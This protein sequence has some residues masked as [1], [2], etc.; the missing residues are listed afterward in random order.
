MSLYLTDRISSTGKRVYTD[1]GFLIIKGARIARSGIQ[2][3][4]AAE[5]P[6]YFGDKEPTDLVS[7]YRPDTEV[8]D[9]ES[10]Q[11]FENKAFAN[12]HP[13]ELIEVR[14]YKDLAIGHVNNIRRDGIFLLADI[15]VI[16]E[17]TIKDIEAGK[18]ELSNGY[19][20]TLVIVKGVTADNE[21]YDAVQ[22]K[23]RG[24]HV[25]L[26]DKARCGPVCSLSDSQPREGVNMKIFIDGV[27][28]EVADESLSAAIQKV[29]TQNAELSS[30]LSNVQATHDTAVSSLKDSYEAEK[31]KLQAKVDQAQANEMT[32]EKLD[33]VIAD[34]MAI[35]D[36]AR[37]VIKD[38]DGKGKTCMQIKRDVLAHKFGDSIS[39]EKMKQDVY[40]DARFDGLIESLGASSSATATEALLADAAAKGKSTEG[41]EDAVSIA[42]EKKMISDSIAYKFPVG[43]RDISH[44]RY[45]DFRK[46]VESEYEKRQARKA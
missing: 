38:F 45:D 16:D 39:A 46:A 7:I 28:F 25:A 1:E 5:L 15:T 23:I 32:P 29:I 31:Q 17:D 6:E 9:K 12:E 27:P 41:K 34:R 40:V 8:F 33:A 30:K 43:A 19:V 3:Y 26:V 42:R 22:T 11:S 14:N 13:A 4:L 10:M 20:S 24:N 37:K 35:V 44:P 2:Q 36:S 18:R 21:P